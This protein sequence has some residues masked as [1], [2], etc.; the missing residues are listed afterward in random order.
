MKNHYKLVILGG[1]MGGIPMAARMVKHLGQG[2]VAVID[3]AQKHYYQPL[4]TIAGAG[5]LDKKITE[6]NQVEM[7]PAGVDWI[8]DLAKKVDPEKNSIET[9][10]SGDVITYDYLIVATGLQ[11]DW[12]KIEGLEGHLGKNGL[13]SI[14]DYGT[15]DATAEAIQ[16]FNGGNAVFT[17]PPV[18]IKCAGA[19]QKI[20]YLAEEIFREHGVREKTKVIWMSN[21]K[22]MFGV[23]EYMK[24]LTAVVKRKNIET[25]FFHRLVKVNA[26]EKKAFFDI[27]EERN[28]NGAIHLEKVGSTDIQYDLLHIVPPMSAHAYVKE[29]GLAFVEG[30]QAGWLKVDQHTLQHLDYKNIFGVGDVTGVPNSKTGAA[31]RMMAPI[32]E[33][34]ILSVMRGDLPVKK[35]NGYSSCPLITSKKTVMLAEFGYDNK[36]MPSFPLDSTK[37]RWIYWILKRYILPKIYWWGMSKGLM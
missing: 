5:L 19:P 9:V 30:P 6:K 34:N 16:N 18:P 21:G 22:A 37:E 1:G 2:N 26:A 24:A 27:F 14:Y 7:I 3:S 13:V 4:W 33:K 11:L 25:H 15:V 17:M 36:L 31:I 32:V 28:E 20:M 12:H 10:N 23:P 35:Y 8:Q 29:S